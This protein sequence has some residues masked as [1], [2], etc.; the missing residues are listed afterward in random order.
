MLLNTRVLQIQCTH[1]DQPTL[2]GSV[3]R[4]VRNFVE[5]QLRHLIF[6]DSRLSAKMKSTMDPS[7]ISTM[8]CIVTTS[9]QVVQPMYLS[10]PPP[11]HTHTCTQIVIGGIFRGSGRQYIGAIM[12]F[13]AYYVIGLPLGITLALKVKWGILGLWIGMNF[14]CAFLVRSII[15]EALI[16]S[17]RWGGQ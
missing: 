10:P 5:G 1:F 12:N 14:G 17:I 3:Y 6:A 8:W 9:N 7:K 2:L 15:S 13:I 11:Q 4:I 16:I